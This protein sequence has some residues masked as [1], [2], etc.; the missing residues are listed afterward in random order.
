MN[1]NINLLTINRISNKDDE[2]VNPPDNGTSFITVEIRLHVKEKWSI[3]NILLYL[4]TYRHFCSF[5]S[6]IKI[7]FIYCEICFDQ[8]REIFN[9]YLKTVLFLNSCLEIAFSFVEKII[10]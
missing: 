5:L 1:G 10:I 2:K 3:E 7:K 4:K 8:N 6:L 9:N